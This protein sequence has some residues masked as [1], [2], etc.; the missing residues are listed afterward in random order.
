MS[1]K[2]EEAM[3]VEMGKGWIRAAAKGKFAVGC[4]TIVL[5][6]W[7]VA[8]VFVKY[9]FTSTTCAIQCS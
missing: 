6:A 5:L 3:A 8:P 4:C 1:K 9:Y 7:I 2:T